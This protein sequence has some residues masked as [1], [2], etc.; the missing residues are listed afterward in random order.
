M[1]HCL[2][3]PEIVEQIVEHIRPVHD[4]AKEQTAAASKGRRL[5]MVEATLFGLALTCRQ[6]L[7]PSLNALWRN[8]DSVTPIFFVL[9]VRDGQLAEEAA[10]ILETADLGRPSY[11]FCRIRTLSA[12]QRDLELAI[13]PLEKIY[14]QNRLKVTPYLQH[15]YWDV[16]TKCKTFLHK[17]E[18]FCG[19][20]LVRLSVYPIGISHTVKEGCPNFKE[21]ELLN[22]YGWLRDLDGSVSWC[23]RHLNP[24][25]FVDAYEQEL[26]PGS[27]AA[28]A[29]MPSLHHLSAVALSPRSHIPSSSDDPVRP[30]FPA[31]RELRIRRVRIDLCG[32]FLQALQN[33]HLIQQLNIGYEHTDLDAAA[34]ERFVSLV[35]D[36]CAPNSLTNFALMLTEI[37]KLATRSPDEPTLR[38]TP[39][40]L[41]PLLRFSKLEHCHISTHFLDYDDAFVKSVA[42]AFPNLVTLTLLWTAEY[43]E[44]S[45]LTL[46]S[47]YF[48]AKHCGK[49][50]DVR[51]NRL[52][53]QGVEIVDT[54]RR[55]WDHGTRFESSPRLRIRTWGA[56]TEITRDEDRIV[57]WLVD[58]FPTVVEIFIGRIEVRYP[59]DNYRRY[60]SPIGWPFTHKFV[61]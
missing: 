40:T 46:R 54:E 17:Y 22:E 53:A 32:R 2:Q 3:I 36:I 42:A 4:I 1:H 28:L 49:L 25:H 57:M 55:T 44:R 52:T 15:L 27:V 33:P 19:P 59:S 41:K 21:M 23:I 58:I 18:I 12:A 5:C 9:G 35:G 16:P 29:A 7:E 24:M 26:M 51:L 45:K 50:E 48:L 8:L 30:F 43:Q 13:L 39:E 31:L 60:L 37:G 14:R 47:L 34:L 56:D 11:Y 6:F 61:D 10:R 20:H 38:V